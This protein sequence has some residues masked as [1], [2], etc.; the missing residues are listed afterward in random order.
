MKKLGFL[1]L[2]G[3]AWLNLQGATL[4]QV[5]DGYTSPVVA[6]PVP[7]AKGKLVIVDQIG[8]ATVLTPG[9][10]NTPFLDLR[11]RMTKINKGFDER[12]FLGL[13]F[14]PQFS[15]NKKFYV[16]YSAPLRT[17]APQGWDHTTHVS[18]F[19]VFDNQD[20]FEADP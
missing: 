13:A 6:A 16:F 3:A 7:G 18:E 11:D 17:D 2:C 4:K 8:T 10:T 14:H 15:E 19:K 5:G 1:I 12:G 9:G 20:K